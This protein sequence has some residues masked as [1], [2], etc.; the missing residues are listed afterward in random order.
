MQHRL[1]T[2]HAEVRLEVPVVV[3][4]QGAHPFAGR[5]TEFDHRVGEL[6]HALAVLAV[7][8]GVVLVA[9]GVRDDLLVMEQPLGPPEQRMQEKLLIHHQTIHSAPPW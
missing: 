2:R 1:H 5:D 6:A 8:V 4:R 9:A 7:G 3:P